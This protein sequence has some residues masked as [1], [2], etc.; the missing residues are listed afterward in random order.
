M[1]PWATLAAGMTAGSGPLTAVAAHAPW[2]VA[3]AT[4][5][6]GFAMGWLVVARFPWICRQVAIGQA[7][8]RLSAAEVDCA[9]REL[10]ESC[11]NR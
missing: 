2:P 6:V 8:L 9:V 1:N 3:L 10:Q 5:A 11:P 4:V 7:E